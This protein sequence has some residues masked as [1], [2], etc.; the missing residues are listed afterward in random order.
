MNPGADAGMREGLGVASKGM[1][2]ATACV[3]V[4][5]SCA[6]DCHEHSAQKPSLSA[7]AGELELFCTYARS[8]L[9]IVG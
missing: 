9:G 4:A 2:A 7:T 5:V 1:D 6:V 3:T 8:D